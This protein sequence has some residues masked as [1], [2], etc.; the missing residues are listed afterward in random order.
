MLT[1]VVPLPAVYLGLTII[2]NVLT[3]LVTAFFARDLFTGSDAAGLIAALAVMTANTFHLG[4]GGALYTNDLDPSTIVL[5][6]LMACIWAG[7]RQRPLLSAI[8]AGLAAL[9]HP[10]TGP[11]TGSIMLGVLVFEQIGHRVWP[12]FFPRSYNSWLLLGNAAI[13]GGFS[14]FVILPTLSTPHIPSALFI[15]IVAYFRNP[16]HLVPS[17]WP[18]I[19]YILALVFIVGAGAAWYLTW[20][21]SPRLR[22]LTPALLI[23][24]AILLFLSLG[25]YVFIELIPMRLWA[26]AQ[27][28]RLLYIFKWLGLVLMSGWIGHFLDSPFQ[29]KPA[30]GLRLLLTLAA[31]LSTLTI[32][33]TFGYELVRQ[34][35]K[36]NNRT[37]WLDSAILVGALMLPFVYEFDIQRYFLVLFFEVMVLAMLFLRPAW[38]GALVVIFMAL[39]LVGPR[40]WEYA[41]P[42][43]S[44][45]S[46]M[47]KLILSQG[48]LQGEEI[49][50]ANY[51]RMH[52]PVGAIFL[53]SP[54]MGDFRVNAS[55]AIVVDFKAWP[56]TDQAMVEWQQRL[57][58]CFGVP[59]AMGFRAADE[60]EENFKNVT[61]SKLAE[62][63]AKF[64]ASYA[65]LFR[66]TKT[67][68]QVI[69]Q[70]KK[71]KIIQLK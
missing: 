58:Y 43:I 38:L 52:T 49:D 7:L 45:N 19:L 56:F 57:F 63:S 40:I 69:F 1:R 37:L 47:P 67:S 26:A 6:L 28:F 5:P 55:G 61:D 10:L 3:A 20:S 70:T 48:D 18:A 41:D 9:L 4:N 59:A 50:L 36:P 27:T 66:N 71:Y 29:V 13:L 35:I 32:L 25:G 16:H 22:Q 44:V 51:A 34:K 11:E 46:I 65:V 62:I 39:G 53:V 14:A 8:F 68:Y 21:I 33:L 15:Q 23:L 60:M 31:L 54:D 30:T 12:Q 2:G 64:D 17:T 24:C 42:S